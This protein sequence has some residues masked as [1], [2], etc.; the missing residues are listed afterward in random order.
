MTAD[1]GRPLDGK[2][3][4]ITGGTAGIGLGAVHLFAERGAR[5]VVGARNRAVG[6]ELERSP[7]GRVIFRSADVMQEQ[8]VEALVDAAVEE[9]GR[10][11]VFYSNA[12]LLG[13]PSPLL[14]LDA[15][16]FDTTMALVA[17][18]VFFAHKHGGRQMVAQGS[19]GSFISTTSMAGCQAGWAAAGYTIA[20]HAI[21]G[22]V[23]AAAH[24][25]GKHGIRSNAIAP[26]IIMTPAMPRTFKIDD[27][28]ADEFQEFLGERLAGIQPVGRVGAVDD[29]AQTAAF[30]ASDASSFISGVH[31]PVDGG[32][33]S[34]TH[35]NF[36]AVAIQ[37][38][39]DFRKL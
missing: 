23:R 12:A 33:L 13:D 11:D 27:E 32:A 16:A 3:A 36:P 19:G 31:I 15:E 10:L 5:V 18:S 8:D 7:P 29:I 17:R 39:R 35:A 14:E 34:V 30:L 20:K 2:V 24:E 28:R 4:I 9:F 26:G 25:L 22:I 1:F 21:M 6:E 38:S 37:A